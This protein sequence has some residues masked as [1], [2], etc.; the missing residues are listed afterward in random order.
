ML[1]CSYWGAGIRVFDIRDPYRPKEIAYY[2]PGARRDQFLPA[3]SLWND[4]GGKIRTTDRVGSNIRFNTVNGETHLW[5]IGQ[6]N[7]FMIAKF[8][9]PLAELLR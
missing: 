4:Y 2:K 6:D 9:K 1:A 7:G 8:T 5:F 3:S